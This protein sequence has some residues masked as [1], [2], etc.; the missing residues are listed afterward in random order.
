[1]FGTAPPT[2]RTK[3]TQT[4]RAIDERH[5]TSHHTHICTY[6]AHNE[7][8]QKQHS[9][10][11]CTARVPFDVHN[12]C[13]NRRNAEFEC[14][15][16]RRH[17]ECAEVACGRAGTQRRDDFVLRSATNS[18]CTHHQNRH[19][20][21]ITHH[22]SPPQASHAPAHSES[23]TPRYQWTRRSPPAS[24]PHPTLGAHRPQSFGWLW[25]A[26]RRGFRPRF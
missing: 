19:T 8:S 16:H 23:Y 25:P 22:T 3:R 20:S 15:D 4:Y 11:I 2:Q 1:M 10:P 24:T 18:T 21:H 7:R 14:S 5:I 26:D 17:C 13:Q 6:H 12:P 9:K